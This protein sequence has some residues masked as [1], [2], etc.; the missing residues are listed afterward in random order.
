[1]S[2]KSTLASQTLSSPFHF[3]HHLLETSNVCKAHSAPRSVH[4]PPP[5]RH[6][7]GHQLPSPPLSI[8]SKSRR[9]RICDNK[10]IIR[11]E[12]LPA[13]T[14]AQIL[15]QTLPIHPSIHLPTPSHP[16]FSHLHISNQKKKEAKMRQREGNSPS[17]TPRPPRPTPAQTHYS[18]N[19][20]PRPRPHPRPPSPSTSYS[21]S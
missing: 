3:P 9:H 19:K 2:M 11:L 10:L 8:S 21:G 15:I 1:M 7:V 4:S 18:H 5:E 6:P 12:A 17:T 20:T 13:I 14:S 16:P